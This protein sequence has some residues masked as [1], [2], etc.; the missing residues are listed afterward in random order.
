MLNRMCYD[1]QMRG[2][3]CDGT[4]DQTWSGCVYRKTDP[5]AGRLLDFTVMDACTVSLYCLLTAAGG[6]RFRIENS[7]D[8][9]TGEK[10]YADYLEAREKYRQAVEACR[11]PY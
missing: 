6:H 1:C 2:T 4:E 7:A 3:E 8:P 11:E 5:E 10:T 9:E